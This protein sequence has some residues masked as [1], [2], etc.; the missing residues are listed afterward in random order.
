MDFS[1]LYPLSHEKVEHNYNVMLQHLDNLML[2]GKEVFDEHPTLLAKH[3]KRFNKAIGYAQLFVLGQ[4]KKL[5]DSKETPG[6][7]V[8]N[9]TNVEAEDDNDYD[10]S[11]FL[12]ESD[13][14][15]E[16]VDETMQEVPHPDEKATSILDGV[17]DQQ[18]RDELKEENPC[19]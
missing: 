18:V 3:T 11:D 14:T 4:Q 15:S 6:S 7:D 2:C 17:S 8:S 9:D 12:Y 10:D 5:A 1:T 19:K 13:L 16:S